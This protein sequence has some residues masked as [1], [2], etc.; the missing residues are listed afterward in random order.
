MDLFKRRIPATGRVAELRKAEGKL[1]RDRQ[2]PYRRLPVSGYLFDTGK[3]VRG[4]HGTGPFQAV[5]SQLQLGKDQETRGSPGARL[6]ERQGQPDCGMV[7]QPLGQ[8]AGRHSAAGYHGILE[9]RGQPACHGREQRAGIR[10]RHSACQWEGP[11][12]GA[13]HQCHLPQEQAVVL[14][15]A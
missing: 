15:G 7:P 2:R 5:Q 4:I 1:W 13:G 3:S 14:S 10:V 6:P 9:H 8:P 12:M 11:K